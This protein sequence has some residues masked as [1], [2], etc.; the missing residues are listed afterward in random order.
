MARAVQVTL[1]CANT[2]WVLFITFGFES[3][4]LESKSK[5]TGSCEKIKYQW[6]LSCGRAKQLL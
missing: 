5:P 4:G 6:Q 2:I 1:V 3:N